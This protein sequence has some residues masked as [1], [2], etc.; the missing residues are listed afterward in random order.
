MLTLENRLD[1]TMGILDGVKNYFEKKSGSE[2]P[3]D[4]G[5]RKILK[6]AVGLG[7]LRLGIS[8]LPSDAKA[9][10]VDF[11]RLPPGIANCRDRL[12]PW[13]FGAYNGMWQY[14][15]PRYSI[16]EMLRM[17]IGIQ[18]R[19]ID[20]TTPLIEPAVY[21]LGEWLNKKE[22]S[23]QVPRFYDKTNEQIVL[24]RSPAIYYFAKGLH[25]YFDE[26]VKGG[27]GHELAEQNFIKSIIYAAYWN[28]GKSNQQIESE[29]DEFYS[30]DLN[31]KT[32]MAN[33]IMNKLKA[34][35]SGSENSKDPTNPFNRHLVAAWCAFW[36][37]IH[38]ELGMKDMSNANIIYDNFEKPLRKIDSK[39]FKIRG[40]PHYQL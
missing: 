21:F 16:P 37:E 28:N 24:P 30:A 26:W 29:S 1:I 9:S 11:S 12:V 32:S 5:R 38:Y 2:L 20:V 8:A 35:G 3:V 34:M 14:P 39:N 23:S 27:T 15:Q 40:P 6:G 18:G 13:I 19:Q 4:K 31:K 25:Y 17:K 36:L 10:E 22:Y 7:A 33:E